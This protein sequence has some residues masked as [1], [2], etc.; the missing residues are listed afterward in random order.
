MEGNAIEL[1]DEWKS[2]AVCTF[3]PRQRQS[4]LWRTAWS[5]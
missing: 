5:I 2:D 3:N 1:E 4:D